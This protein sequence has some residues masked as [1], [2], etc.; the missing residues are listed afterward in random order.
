MDEKNKDQRV[1]WL[2]IAELISEVKVNA[3]NVLQSIF[4]PV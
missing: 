1:R 2:K 4:K 3:A